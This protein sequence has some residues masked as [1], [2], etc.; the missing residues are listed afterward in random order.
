M[1]G[2]AGYFSPQRHLETLAPLA[3]MLAEI[4]HRGPDDEGL[5]AIDRRRGARLELGRGADPEALR[6]RCSHDLGLAHC[7]LAS[8]DPSDAG[9][10][11]I[12]NEARSLVAVA[13]GG[14][15]N[16][17]ELREELEKK[18]HRFRGASDTE[19]VLRAFEEWDLDAFRRLNG[20]W[21]LALYDVRRRRLVLSRDRIG[22]CPLYL[23]VSRGVLYFAS[24]PKAIVAVAGADAFPV[25]EG[26]VADFVAQGW[27]DVDHGTF[28]RGIR[29]LENASTAVVEDDLGIRPARYWRLPERRLEEKEIDLRE[30][31]DT[32]RDL[33]ADA[34]RI[35]LRADVPL[36]MQ[37]SGD[38]DSS[39][40][41]A[42][43]ASSSEAGR[44]PVYT[45]KL[46]APDA[47]E[48]ALARQVAGRWVRRVDHHVIRPPLLEFWEHADAFTWLMGEPYRAPSLLTTHLIGRRIRADGYKV[49][50]VGAGGD[51]LLAGHPD[52]YSVPFLLSL[53]GNGTP[54]EVVRELVSATR[55]QRRA[56][57]RRCLLGARRPQGVHPELAALIPARGRLDAGPP[58]SFEALLR[59]N[60]GPWKMHQW[61]RSGDPVHGGVPLEARAPFADYRVAELAFQLPMTYLIRRGRT[62][63]VLRHALESLLPPQVVWR[64][65]RRG[66]PFP[67]HEW[68]AASKAWILANARGSSL[69]CVGASG[70][71]A[72]YDALAAA[73]PVGLWRLASVLLWHRRCNEGRALAAPGTA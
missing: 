19:V 17:P 53:L 32:L 14:V 23:G 62:K 45:V 47:D 38:V 61:L 55:A 20:C 49:L 63:Y 28:Y 59:A 30:A 72:R 68:I 26:A 3:R 67:W 44:F 46:D 69:A 50:I 57:A 15:Y 65:Q 24:E 11:P 40:L 42:L 21:A 7:R 73:D 35:R 41:V 34:V 18:G 13:D 8:V 58:T 22:K 16:H 39:S 37:L 64:Q 36:A 31:G 25:D 70:L 33:L 27:R 51:A 56:L 4:R 54:P 60:W 43:R 71:A 10:Q 5:L 12:W 52:A 6:G 2:I 48:E 29:T 1:G 66:H 9:H